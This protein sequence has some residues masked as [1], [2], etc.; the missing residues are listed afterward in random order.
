MLTRLVFVFTALISQSVICT[1]LQPPDVVPQFRAHAHNDY[2]HKRPLLDALQHGFTSVEAD[3]ILKDG[4]L[5]VGHSRFELRENRTL[6]ALY[7]APLAKRVSENDG[8]V[9]R[10][11]KRF[12][13]LIDFKSNGAASLEVL[14]KQL[15]PYLHML[16]RYENGK[17]HL[18]AVTIIISG[19][20]PVAEVAALKTRYVFIDGRFADLQAKTRSDL[21][22]LVSAPWNGTFS[23]QGYGDISAK[24]L[25]RLRAI[26]KAAHE[27][28]KL[29][30]FWAV[31][32]SE[33]LWQVFYNEGIDL[34]NADD[35]PRLQK[36]LKTQSDRKPTNK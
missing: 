35:L 11:A 29:V 27:Q 7:L 36:F 25:Q 16:T 28:D 2:Y 31:P 13:L 1:A 34:I 6:T 10:A 19:S 9:Y 23:W 22:P 33:N 32:H 3:V 20:R 18:G 21:V 12:I 4:D 30:R 5:M 26:I 17:I 8:Q 24:E 14:R 15:Q